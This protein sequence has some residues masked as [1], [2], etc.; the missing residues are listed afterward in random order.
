ML[1]HGVRNGSVGDQLNR[2]VVI[3]QLFGRKDVRVVAV[4]VS[5]DANDLLD[6]TGDGS[7]VVRDHDDGHVVIQLAERIVELLFEAVV[8][9]VRG[10]VED[11]QAGFGDDGSGEQGAL[12]LPAGNFAD[13]VAGHLFES[14]LSDQLHGTLLVLPRVSRPESVMAL[15]TGEDDLEY[16][17]RESAIELRDLGH[18]TDQPFAAAEELLCVAD[19][20]GVGDGSEN[21]LY[22]GCFTAAVGS[23]DPEEIAVEDLEVDVLQGLVSVVSDRNVV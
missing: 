8:D 7:D 3:E 21:G 14:R 18:I 5:V 12:H 19:L 15:Q 13:R 9:E 16:G 22:E 23:D 1:Q 11:Q 17:D 6:D 20:A 4:Y 10:F 2:T